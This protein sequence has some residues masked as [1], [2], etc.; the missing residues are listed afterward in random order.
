MAKWAATTDNVIDRGF[1]DDREGRPIQGVIIH[2]VA[3]TNGLGYVSNANSRNSHPTYHVA[4]SGTVTGIVHPNRQPFSTAHDVDNIAVTFEV[5]NERTGGD[6]PITDASL[7]ALIQ[8]ILDHGNQSGRNGF[9]KNVRG[10]TQKEFFVGWHGQ[11]VQTECPGPYVRGKIDY[12]VEECNRRQKTP[13][14]APASTPGATPTP[15]ADRP[16]AGLALVKS[17][18]GKGWAFNLPSTA[19]TPR[20]L[21]ALAKR[22]PPRYT[23]PI[24]SRLNVDGAKGIQ[25]TLRGVGYDGPIDGDIRKV[26]CGLIQEYAA[27]FGDY[28]GPKDEVLGK[29]SWEGFILG[30]ERP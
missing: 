20:L 7:E 8:V 9:A 17:T 29:Y 5:D 19:Q 21:R 22:R 2:H 16:R 6:W 27:K 11:Y 4:R 26:G 23:G 13:S 1:G 3:G 24:V 15:I 14:S 25:I 18:K 10:K 12:I 30:L 28:D